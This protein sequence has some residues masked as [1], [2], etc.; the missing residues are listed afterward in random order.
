VKKAFIVLLAL[1]V[2]V[3]FAQP[4][5]RLGVHVDPLSTWLSPKSA[6][7]EKDGSHVGFSW[8]MIV[9][10]Y[11]HPNYGLVSGLS[12]TFLGGNLMY[13]VPVD[14]TVGSSGSETSIPLEAGTTVSFNSN[15]LSLPV[16]LKLKTNEIGYFTYYAQMGLRQYINIG[17]RATASG[18]GLSKDNVSKEINL[19]NISYFFGGGFEYKIGGN[20]SLTA[21]I[22]YD[23]GFVDVL[24][25]DDHKAVYNFVTIRLGVLF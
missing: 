22:F 21:G 1:N 9:E 4:P 12:M 3:V 10:Y 6:D 20:T 18:S 23:N 17:A 19:L 13:K 24:S 2:S 8:G 11:F 5:V 15:Y 25:N 14:I 16:A 7:I